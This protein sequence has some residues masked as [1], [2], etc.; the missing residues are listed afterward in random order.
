MSFA[1]KVKKMVEE[2]PTVT[3]R[4]NVNFGPTTITPIVVHWMGQGQTPIKTPLAQYMQEHGLD[5]DDD[6]E[7]DPAKESFQ[8]HFD[9]D[10]SEL[11]P[12][13]AFHYE[14]DVKI[15]E[16]NKTNKD[17][18]KWLL[19]SW[20]EIV[21]PALEKVLGKDWYNKALPNGKKAAPVLFLAIE[22]VDQV[23]PIKEGKKSFG[24]P[25]I[26]GI[27]KDL[28]ELRKARDERYPPRDEEGA[29]AFGEDEEGEDDADEGFPEEVLEQVR[30]LYKSC[31]KNEKQTLKIMQGSEDYEDYD[32]KELL[33][34]ALA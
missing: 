13:L 32:P 28:D 1:D 4:P 22:S 15:T 25:K 12:S 7:L 19:T 2:A 29:M 23:E 3:G 21:H 9:C 33:A 6:I 20:S 16:S 31:R 24:V 14:R 5:E 18:K 34:A 26:I 11:N 8:L 27:Y 30:Q 17:P 10:V